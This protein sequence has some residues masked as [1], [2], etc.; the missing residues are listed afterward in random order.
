MKRNERWQRWTY[1]QDKI[2]TFWWSK[3]R[4]WITSTKSTKKY[5]AGR[6][7][8]YIPETSNIKRKY[9]IHGL[10]KTCKRDTRAEHKKRNDNFKSLFTRLTVLFDKF[11]NFFVSNCN[12]SLIQKYLFVKFVFDQWKMKRDS[13]LSQMQKI[14]RTVYFP[15]P[16]PSQLRHVTDFSSSFQLLRVTEFDFGLFFLCWT[17]PENFHECLM[18]WCLVGNVELKMKET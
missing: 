9:I 1:T 6:F 11:T 14:T 16:K 12:F 7:L 4:N 18:R 15:F 17:L 10:P 8:D 3:T 2:L 13:N 5:E